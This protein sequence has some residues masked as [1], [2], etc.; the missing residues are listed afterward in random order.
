MIISM[1]VNLTK[2]LTSTV[3]PI[4]TV[5]W[6]TGTGEAP[7]SVGTFSISITIM[8]TSTTLIHIYIMEGIRVVFILVC[9]NQCYSTLMPFIS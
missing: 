1:D 4:S 6:V 5:S 3:N 9:M 8:T 7:R 2:K